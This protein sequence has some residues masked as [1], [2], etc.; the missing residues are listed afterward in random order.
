MLAV[1]RLEQGCSDRLIE[2]GLRGAFVIPVNSFFF[3]IT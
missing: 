3:Y 2:G 1:C